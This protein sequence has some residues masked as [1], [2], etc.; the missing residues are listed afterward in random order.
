M[1][2]RFSKGPWTVVKTKRKG[3]AWEVRN[4]HRDPICVVYSSEADARVIAAALTL[5]SAV[6]HLIAIVRLFEPELRT[7]A[8]AKLAQ[9]RALVN[10]L[11][12]GN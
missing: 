2:S 10:E 11:N 5:L 3:W 7:S 12:G 6:K 9:A 1:A 8:R 4:G